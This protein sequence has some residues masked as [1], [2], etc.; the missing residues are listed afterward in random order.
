MAKWEDEIKD[1]LA[2][3]NWEE[4]PNL[5][6][7]LDQIMPLLMFMV[8]VA[9][10]LGALERRIDSPKARGIIRKLL[11]DSGVPPDKIEQLIYKMIENTT[12]PL[13]GRGE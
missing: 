2:K 5:G 8:A 13:K 9:T 7:I 1:I 3:T 6:E 10:G 12:E 4:Q 11:T